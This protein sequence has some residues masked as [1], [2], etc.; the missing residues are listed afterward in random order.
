MLP[1]L[2]I[3]NIFLHLLTS[4]SFRNVSFSSLSLL[5]EMELNEKKE[6]VITIVIKAVNEL[7]KC[8]FFRDDIDITAGF[9]CFDQSPN[10]VTFRGEI[11]LSLT[12]NS[13]QVISYLEQ[14]VATDPTIIVLSSRLSVDSSC[15][16]EISNFNDPE[17]S[18]TDMTSTSTKAAIIGGGVG[19]VFVILVAALALVV[20]VGL[21][22][23]HQKRASYNLSVGKDVD[24]NNIYE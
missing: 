8:V 15:S 2:Y 4:I 10:A 24:N 9:Q 13:S 12:A 14:W 11:G 21:L 23:T 1:M 6:V 3:T 22:R 5:Q 19:G 16:V 17:C 7:C 20:V 18:D